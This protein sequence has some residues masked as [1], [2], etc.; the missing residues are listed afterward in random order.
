MKDCPRTAT[1]SEATP[2]EPDEE[3]PEIPDVDITPPSEPDKNTES[4]KTS[5]SGGHSGGNSSTTTNDNNSGPGVSKVESEEELTEE[6]TDVHQTEVS[7]DEQKE[8]N[9]LP[10]TGEKENIFWIIF[11]I[12]GLGLIIL[13]MH[14]RKKFRT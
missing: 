8:Q 13:N 5:V 2:S 14:K 7:T 11:Q 6:T 4:P 1:E 3:E 9:L 10:K 12:S